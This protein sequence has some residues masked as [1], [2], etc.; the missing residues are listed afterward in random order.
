MPAKR[1]A[2][3]LQKDL[4]T[5][6]NAAY[7]RTAEAAAVH[8]TETSHETSRAHTILCHKPFARQLG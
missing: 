8:S 4:P 7:F 3:D 6:D 5:A 1:S 2:M